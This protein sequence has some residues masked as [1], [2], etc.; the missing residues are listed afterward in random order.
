MQG[1]VT[2]DTGLLNAQAAARGNKTSF[3][4]VLT[5][6]ARPDIPLEGWTLVAPVTVPT[7]QAGATLSAVN[8]PEVSACVSLKAQNVSPITARSNRPGHKTYTG[9]RTRL[10]EGNMLAEVFMIWLEALR[11]PEATTTASTSTFVPFN[12]NNLGSLK[13]IRRRQ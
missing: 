13:E 7:A 12:R 2:A 9:E 1:D 10:G 11:R 3:A 5:A 8:H 4:G 6:G